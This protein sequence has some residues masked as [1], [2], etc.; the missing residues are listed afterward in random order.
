MASSGRTAAT[1]AMGKGSTQF[2]HLIQ[3]EVPPRLLEEWLESWRKHYEHGS[4][5]RVQLRPHTAG[6]ELLE[7]RLFN[8]AGEKIAYVIFDTIHD[9]RGR[10]ILTIRDQNMVVSYRK[11]RLMTLVHLFLLHRYKVASV[12]YLSPTEDNQLQSERMKGLGIYSSVNTEIG[13][14][15]VADVNKDRVGDLLKP[16]RQALDALIRKTPV[17]V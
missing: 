14:L 16:D 15:I 13:Q 10:S 9:R 2:Q 5:I 6:S 3:T 17:A 1:K 8:D 4:R 7:L 12:H 11:K